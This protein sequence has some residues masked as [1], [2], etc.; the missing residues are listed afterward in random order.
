MDYTIA[1]GSF[2][3]KIP[4]NIHDADINAET[5]EAPPERHGLT[6][7]TIPIDMYKICNV[8]RQIMDK[9]RAPTLADQRRLVNELYRTIE[10][11]CLQYSTESDGNIAWWVGLT[12][13]RLT[14][15]KMTLFINF[16]ML[17]SS[18]S[19][20]ST[21]D[22]R[23]RLLVAA[24]EVAEWN[25]ALNAEQEAR[26]WRWIY[27]TYTHWHAI[28]LLLLEI[29][30]RPLSPIVERAWLALR[31]TWLIPAQGD[32]L[33]KLQIWVPLRKLMAQARRHRNA[34]IERLRANAQAIE[35]TAAEDDNIPAPASPCPFLSQEKLQEHW[36]SLFTTG[37]LS[38][39][40]P[41]STAPSQTENSPQPVIVAQGLQTSPP[42]LCYSSMPTYGRE[43]EFVARTSVV[44]AQSSQELP[45]MGEHGLP[46]LTVP[47]S[48]S[49][50][51]FGQD[52][53]SAFTQAPPAWSRPQ[54]FDASSVPWLWA[55]ADPTTDVFG[56]D[57]VSCV[58][59]FLKHASSPSS[60]PDSC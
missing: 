26:Q 20:E 44:D 39:G 38:G 1:S 56:A 8:T 10:R 57:L 17:F 21:I 55:D 32:G 51:S 5:K 25:H 30:R 13:V 15:A 31:S 54:M 40:A 2:D 42:Q 36:R 16:P 6:A 22:T 49:G 41:A 45:D 37:A 52:T 47:G 9:E 12:S 28:I 14:M 53:H 4:R 27:Q 33:D 18:A 19:V 23:N 60:S 58:E 11:G 24:V 48:E 29:S 59:A 35:Q 34:E 7:M 3:T 50:Q 43:D 46:N